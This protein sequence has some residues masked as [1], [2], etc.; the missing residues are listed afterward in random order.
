MKTIG[1]SLPR[2][3]KATASGA[4]TAGKPLI[5]E[6]DGNVAEISQTTQALGSVTKVID[7]TGWI[8]VGFDSTNNKIVVAY[9]DGLDSNKGKAVVGTVSDT[10][11]SYGSPVEFASGSTTH[12]QVGFDENA[13]KIVIAYKDNGNSFYGTAVVGTVSGTSI[14]FGTPVVFKS[15]NTNIEGTPGI[16]YHA[17]QQKMLIAYATSTVGQCV[18]GTV[19]GTSISFGT[20]ITFNGTSA[21]PSLAYHAASTNFVVVYVDTA[22]ASKGTARVG[23]LSGTTV[24]FPGNEDDFEAYTCTNTAITYDSSAEKCIIAINSSNSPYAKYVVATVSG[25]TLS[26]PEPP[27]QFTESTY[28]IDFP[29]VIYD[30]DANKTVFAWEATGRTASRED[31]TLRVG[32]LSGNT[33]SFGS[34]V[35]YGSGHDKHNRSAYDSAQKRVVI[36]YR[37]ADDTSDG[38]SVVFRNAGIS[39]LTSEN[40][41]GIAE[42]AAADT[43]T[44][45]VLI[46]GGVSTAQ[47]SLTPGQTYFVQGDG[48]LGLTADTPSVTAGTA[49]T[50]TKLIVKG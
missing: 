41:I 40:Y 14:S 33:L 5:V 10:S 16:C 42:Y 17:D 43:E 47:S 28:T 26:T 11:I 23:T 31:G 38:D 45:T 35:I 27:A 6:T 1:G 19:S 24:A 34:V 29:S 20:A 44:A 37:D 15:D 49:V 12:I 21:Y 9:Q 4:I 46:K 25:T 8:A 36:V 2:R 48:T 50:S 32:T 13:G 30:P 18:A 3:F 22:N 7:D 39:T